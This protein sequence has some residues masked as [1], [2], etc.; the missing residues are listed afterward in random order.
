[1]FETLA[2]RLVAAHA[3]DEALGVYERPGRTLGVIPRLARIRPAGRVWRLGDYLLMPSGALLR[4]ARVVRVAGMDRRRSVIAVAAT[5]HHE[6]ALAARRGGFREG[7]TVNFDAIPLDPASLDL[8]VLE[9]YL[10]DRA[11]LLIHPPLGAN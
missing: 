1:M 9:P 3:R 7:E 6:L 11:E 4:T 10:D 2:A 8:P 5:E